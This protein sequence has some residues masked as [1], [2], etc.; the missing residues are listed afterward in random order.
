MKYGTRK[1]FPDI[2]REL[3]KGHGR[4]FTAIRKV[5]REKKSRVAEGG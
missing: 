5:T 2:G 4:N 3:N 1:T